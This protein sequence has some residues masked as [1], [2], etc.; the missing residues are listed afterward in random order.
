MGML[1][2]YDDQ[3]YNVVAAELERSKVRRRGDVPLEDEMLPL[4]LSTSQ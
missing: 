4:V 2:N 1:G 3:V